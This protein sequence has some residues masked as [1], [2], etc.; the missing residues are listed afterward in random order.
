MIQKAGK[1]LTI[2]TEKHCAFWHLYCAWNFFFKKNFK[3]KTHKI[4]ANATDMLFIIESTSIFLA[5]EHTFTIT[6]M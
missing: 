1:S 4:I 5:N 2:Q 6:Y 3:K